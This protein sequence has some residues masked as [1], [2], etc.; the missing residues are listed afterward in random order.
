[1]DGNQI[2]LML[3]IAAGGAIGSVLRYSVSGAFTRGDFPWG[4]FIVNFS[5]SLLLAFVFFLAAGKGVMPQDM[6]LFLFVGVFGGYTTLSTFTLETVE[7][8]AETRV[9][10]ALVNIFLNAIVCV[11][12]ALFGRIIGIL[13]GGG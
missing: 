11:G 8:L 6:R 7:L 4:T 10:A 12:G 1:M 13:V 2:K 5:G 9:T 3:L